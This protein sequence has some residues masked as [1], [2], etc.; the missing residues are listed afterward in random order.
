MK[1]RILKFSRTFQFKGEG[2]LPDN[3]ARAK[4]NELINRV[5]SLEDEVTQLRIKLSYIKVKE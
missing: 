5:E 3:I 4:I 1:I 2:S